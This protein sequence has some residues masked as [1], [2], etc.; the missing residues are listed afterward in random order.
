MTVPSRVTPRLV[1]K[2]SAVVLASAGLLLIPRHFLSA[3]LS[4]HA[5]VRGMVYSIKLER[6]RRGASLTDQ[7][8]TDMVNSRRTEMVG[9]VS[10]VTA[11]RRWELR[12][13]LAALFVL[14]AGGLMLGRPS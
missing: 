8:I 2:L 7:Q 11:N 1:H 6:D 12:I 13:G 14:V 5:I 10:E 9:K 4:E 3:R